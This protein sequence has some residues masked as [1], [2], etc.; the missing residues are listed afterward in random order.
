MATHDLTTSDLAGA[1]GTPET[2]PEI[3]TLN[4]VSSS[5]AP[6]SAESAVTRRETTSVAVALLDP[7]ETERFR[8][9]WLDV[10]SGFVD[11]P[12]ESVERADALVAQVMQRLAASF[13]ES[14]A[15]LELAWDG[16]TDVSTEDLRVTMTRYRSFFER[17]LNA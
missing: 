16:N 1:G 5:T 3:E 6:G 12:R 13:A 8:A 7:D 17:L 15:D 11:Q 2:Q 10:Q 4:S 9:E 14:R